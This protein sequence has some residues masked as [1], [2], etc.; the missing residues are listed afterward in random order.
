MHAKATELKPTGEQLF[1]VEAAL[2][3]SAVIAAAARIT[4][5]LLDDIEGLLAT[6]RRRSDPGRILATVLFTDIVDSTHCAAQLGDVRYRELLE[7]HDAKVRARVA[8][9]GGHVLKSLGDGY[10]AMFDS[11]ARAVRCGGALRADAR[12]SGFE[13]KVG[14]HTGECELMGHD[15]TGMAVHIG[16]RVVAEARPGEVLV[17]GTVRDLIVGSGIC[18]ADRGSHTLR[19]IPGAWNLLAARLDGV[20]L[21]CAFGT[22]VVPAARR[23]RPGLLRA[24]LHRVRAAVVRKQLEE[25]SRVERLGA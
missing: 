11:P 9:H 20:A 18:F 12:S 5:P 7:A 2:R 16:A 13:V 14:V 15:L 8:A 3:A 6:E 19:G 1:L 24:V 23:R 25:R 17:T 4:A 22:D 10:L 21:P